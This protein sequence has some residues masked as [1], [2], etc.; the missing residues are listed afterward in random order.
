MV[1]LTATTQSTKAATITSA[2]IAYARAQI[3]KPYLLGH[4]GPD[5]FDC[6][7]LTQSAYKAAGLSIPR[8]TALQAT[9]GSVVARADLQPGDLVF[10]AVNH[11]QLYS[12]GGNVIEAPSAGKKVREVPMWGFLTARRLVNADGS[13]KSGVPVIGGVIDAV[14][15]ATDAASSAATSAASLTDPNTWVAVAI[16]VAAFGLGLALLAIGATKVV[17][18]VATKALDQVGDVQDAVK[19]AVT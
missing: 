1:T 4:A 11:V 7:G 10:T 6:S 12:G 8:N 9:V 17:T 13:A 3:G 18:P 2:A 5:S 15:S 19:G 14:T 16:K